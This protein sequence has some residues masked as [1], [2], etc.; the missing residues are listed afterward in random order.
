MRRITALICAVCI[1]A[2]LSAAQGQQKLKVFISV[3]MEGICGVVNSDHVSSTG[4]DYNRARVWMTDETNAAV[5]GALDA[6]AT[7]IVVND[8]H[9]GMRNILIERLH[10]KA[11]LISGSP[12]HLSMMEGMDATYDAV[13][14]IGYHAG[15]G[16]ANAVLD[17]TMSSARISSISFNGTWMNEASMNAAIAGYYGVPVVCVAGD[18]AVAEQVHEIIGQKIETAVVKDGVGRQAARNVSL[19]RAQAMI[20]ECV[21]RGVANRSAMP[22][23]TIKA[24][25]KLEMEFLRSDYADQLDLIPGVTRVS[26]RKVTY[27][28]DDFIAVYKLMRALLALS[29]T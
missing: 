27:T 11:D 3:D 1:L 22:V 18:R 24:P 17:H 12:K 7:E 20:R 29:G 13:I 19:E 15:M 14:F 28:G 16:T 26:G 25:V 4:K 10:P 2:L 6:G 21:R 8:S 5:Q 9:G 23:Y